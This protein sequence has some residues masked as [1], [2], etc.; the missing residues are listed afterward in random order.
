MVA[1]ATNAILI[2]TNVAVSQAG[3]YQV[4]VANAYGSV[5]SS[6]AILTVLVA[7]AIACGTDR[8]VP[9]GSEWHFDVPA[10]TGNNPVLSVD[11][12]VTNQICGEN[13]NVIRS[14]KVSDDTGLESFCSQTISVRESQ[15]P[16]ILIQP[17][18]QSVLLGAMVQL[19]VAVSNC[20]A[21]TYQWYFNETNLLAE[22]TNA[23]LVLSNVTLLQN[24][25]YA[26]VVMNDYGS[27]TS[28]PAVLDVHVPPFIVT[29]PTNTVVIR[30][31]SAELSVTP[32][33][34]QPLTYQWYFN[35]NQL[36]AEGT[37][38]TLVLNN[39]SLAEAGSYVVAVANGYG[40]VTSTP[41]FL[42]V[43][44]APFIISEPTNVSV[45]FGESAQFVVTAGGD[46]PFTYEW[47]RDE[48]NVIADATNAT[49][50]LTNVAVSQ[51]GNYQVVV[52]NAY[53]SVTSSPAI[54]TVLVA[55]AIACGTDRVVSLGSEWHFDVP[56]IAGNNPVLSVESTVTNQIC[57]ENYNVIRSWKVS[58]D[59]GLESFCSQTISVRESQLPEI[60]IQPESQSVL[61]GA[62][63]RLEV[64]GV[65]NCFTLTY[66][67]YFNETNVLA[68]A[69]NAT[70]VL[71]NVT[72]L[73]IGRYEVVLA[74][75]YGT[76]T[77]SPAILSIFAAPAIACGTDRVVS[78]GSEWDFDV[79]TMTGSNPA[80][81][82]ENTVTNQ[83]C[84]QNY[85]ATRT[86]KVT[87]DTGLEAFCS[88]TI[89]VRDPQ[90]PEILTQP[91]GQSVLFGATVQ[92]EVG[93]SNC[94]VLTY[95]W[96]L[97]ETNVLA[98]ATNA[99]LI[100]SNVTSLQGGSYEVVVTNDYGSVTSSPAVRR[101]ACACLHCNSANEH[102]NH[103][104]PIRRVQRN[105]RRRPAADLSM[106][107]EFD[108]SNFRSE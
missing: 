41:A 29:E 106:V 1:D 23:T 8:V 10:I 32:G 50:I 63:A 2:L 66:Q 20:F 77:S 40:S 38:A 56:A 76:V 90:V 30:G 51:A 55:P 26:A 84:G 52:A 59:T 74:N 36:I 94:F 25:S 93:I 62:T 58:D 53:G 31:Q 35:Q 21:L 54:L 83:I 14:W 18:S 97:N 73:H 108:E 5:T 105:R 13:Y 68:E 104:W 70:L 64:L 91:E 65:S 42:T 75:D 28:S 85:N 15:L 4:V 103:Q 78:L 44:S 61:L 80:L 71:S 43:R 60:L 89:T 3:N 79:P 72:S 9:L 82:V 69:T 7:P 47:R 45:V 96:Y 34:D 39:V 6:P 86:W 24:G 33:G 37:N 67:W 49:L 98:G 17:E 81:T 107:F 16:E 92:L 99:T 87:D 100:L 19:E 101:C 46:A 102:S 88:Q 11:S 22:A 57:G 95:Q 27:V 48:T 12:T